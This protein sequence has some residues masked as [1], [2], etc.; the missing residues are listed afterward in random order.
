[1]MNKKL[2]SMAV[3]AALVGGVGAAQAIHVNTDG[4]GQVLLYPF[5]SVE[6]GND[7]YIQIVNTTDTTKAVKV[8]FLEAM[9]SAEVLDFNL[10]LSPHDHWSGYIGPDNVGPGAKLWTADNSCTVPAIPATGVAFRNL[11]YQGDAPAFRGVDRTRE[12]YV[13]IIEMGVVHGALGNA[14]IHDATGVPAN[15]GLLRQ[16]WLPGGTWAVNPAESVSA[17]S[18]GLYGYGVLINVGEGTDASYDAIS[19]DNFS[20]TVLHTNPGSTLPSLNSGNLEADIIEGSTVFESIL[21]DRSIDAVSAVL[22]RDT[23]MND[24]VTEPL[25]AAETDWVVTFPT[26]RFYVNGASAPIRPFTTKWDPTTATACERIN[27]R[28]WDREEKEEGEDL[29]FSP[30]PPTPAQ[31]LCYEA[32]VITFNG[33]DALFSSDRV[34]RNLNLAAGFDNGWMRI[35]LEGENRYLLGEGLQEDTVEFRGLPV[36][37]FAV[38][39]YVNGNLGGLLSNYGGLVNHKYTRDIV[40]YTFD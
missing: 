25:I 5:Y 28:Y 38:Q 7:T 26:K 29:D 34:K 35:G 9:N 23:L 6:G 11:E 17:P 15:C 14:A 8:R 2:V 21:F 30:T 40:R 39:K 4:L 10:Y 13:E 24:Y 22:M 32:N 27:F 37:G 12:G 36:V 1:M 31:T 20:D 3:A 18:G 33:S 19:I 16:A